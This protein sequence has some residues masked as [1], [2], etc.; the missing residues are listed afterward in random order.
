MATTNKIRPGEIAEQWD[1]DLTAKMHIHKP[2]VAGKPGKSMGISVEQILGATKLPEAA[3]GIET[4]SVLMLPTGTYADYIECDG[5]I[6]FDAE[7]PELAVLLKSGISGPQFAGFNADS[8]E[9]STLGAAVDVLQVLKFKGHYV[10]RTSTA[11]MQLIVTDSSGRVVY[12]ATGTVSTDLFATDKAVYWSTSN[13]VYALTYNNGVFSS[14]YTGQSVTEMK[15]VVAVT[16]KWD[17]FLYTNA[18]ATLYDPVL[19]STSGV[20]WVG[21]V[22]PSGSYIA[23]CGSKGRKFYLSGTLNLA[24]GMFECEYDESMAAMSIKLLQPSNTPFTVLIGDRDSSAVYFGVSYPQYRLDVASGVIFQISSIHTSFSSTLTK[25]YACDDFIFYTPTTA[26]NKAYISFDGGRSW[27]SPPEFNAKLMYV[28]LDVDSAKLITVGSLGSTGS[29][30]GSTG[31][32][33]TNL[34]A[35]RAGDQFVAPKIATISEGHRFY[36]K[37]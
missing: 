28:Y 14:G 13:S 29:V 30:S 9:R 1:G 4:G 22:A 25:G 17:L 16:D 8:E 19:K 31:N 3:A 10:Y 27:S 15:N 5:G 18:P 6:H 24:A 26:G 21:G 32:I 11:G 12:T 7:A 35:L 34:L 23:G 37:K 20:S 33:Q 36:V 2:G